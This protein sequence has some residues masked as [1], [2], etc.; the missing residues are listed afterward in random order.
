MKDVR[1][2]C[3]PIVDLSKITFNKKILSKVAFDYNQFC[4]FFFFFERERE[5][6]V[7][8]NFVVKLC[9]SLK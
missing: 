4:R 9:L 7:S 8:E 1:R 6:K 3:N 5:R 2:R